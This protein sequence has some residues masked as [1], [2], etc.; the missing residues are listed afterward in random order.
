M[1]GAAKLGWGTIKIW[2]TNKITTVHID[3]KCF[4]GNKLN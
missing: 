1:A 2:G 3:V 4:T